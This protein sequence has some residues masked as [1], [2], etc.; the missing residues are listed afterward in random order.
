MPTE[1][2]ITCDASEYT[3]TLEETVQ[4]TRNTTASLQQTGDA[5]TKTAGGLKKGFADLRAELNN[6]VGGAKKLIS[7][8]LAGGGAIGIILAGIA[9]IGKLIAWV[10]EL[11]GRKA[12]DACDLAERNAA[13]I[14]EV[15][16]ANEQLR[17]KTDGYISRLDELART[18]KLGNAG[19]AEALKLVRELTG[20]YGNLGISV[21]KTTGQISGLDRAIERKAE[22]DRARR[23]S[24]AKA[25]MQQIVAQMEYWR[26]VQKTAGYGFGETRFGGQEVHDNATQKL[27]ELAAAYAKENDRYND[28]RRIDPRAIRKNK[29]REAED[30]RLA[31]QEKRDEARYQQWRS[32]KDAAFESATSAEGKRN[33]RLEVLRAEEQRLAKLRQRYNEA[34]EA[35]QHAN[36]G[37]D[38]NVSLQKMLEAEQAM[39]PAEQ[40]VAEVK[41][42]I[43]AL[44]KARALTISEAANAGKKE[45]E[46]NRLIA[47]GEFEKAAALKLQQ[48]LKAK[49]IRLTEA[50]TK[51]IQ[52][53][54]RAIAAGNLQLKLA[55]QARGLRGKA[56]EQAGRGRE[57][58]EEEALRRAA[59]IK[60]GKL[61]AA[62]IANVRKIAALTW[63]TDHRD[64]SKRADMTI[65]S[66]SLTSRG[67][68]A[69]G[70]RMTPVDQ[71]NREIRNYNQQQVQRLVA[72]ESTLHRLLEV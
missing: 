2:K 56:M 35:Y 61:T 62:E 68:F 22:I 32:G 18:E 67:G 21:D 9:S 15:A 30:N 37:H 49:G 42:Q 45:L 59:E 38:A 6:T 66:N 29:E 27:T 63:E 31:V 16:E 28:A 17:Q 24:S 58:A 71:V 54:Q 44:D 1:L 33:N 48:E 4:K 51:K 19:K 47:R 39:I 52:A 65:R 25:A 13:S 57:F 70:V 7:S 11:V 50:E 41:R 46:V 40:T 10:G 26:E 23:M 34:A 53:S 43:A 36:P 20:A 12:K 14:R 55:E 69:S 72:I 64:T 5:G 3:R 60:R 8:L